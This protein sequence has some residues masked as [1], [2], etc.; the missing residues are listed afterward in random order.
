LRFELIL[1]LWG[2]IL[3]KILV[4]LVIIVPGS[5]RLIREEAKFLIDLDGLPRR[6]FTSLY[7]AQIQF[8]D[9]RTDNGNNSCRFFCDAAF[10]FSARDLFAPPSF[11]K[12]S[13]ELFVLF[14]EASFVARNALRFANVGRGQL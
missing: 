8:V 12:P 3:K 2:H 7:I 5:S 11:G 13:R 6:S 14:V 1:H 10:L 9:S 4:I